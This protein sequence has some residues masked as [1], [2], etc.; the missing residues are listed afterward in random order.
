MQDLKFPLLD[1]I[2]STSDLKKLSVDQLPLLC[3]EL[4]KFLIYSIS[5]SSGHFASNLGT[6]E[7]TVALHYVYDS[8]VDKII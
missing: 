1:K 8:P 5:N 6:I 7:L 4:R 3:D 2:N